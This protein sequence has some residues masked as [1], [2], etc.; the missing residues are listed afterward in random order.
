MIWRVFF[1]S[2]VSTYTLSILNQINTNGYDNITLSGA[3][4]LK[5]GQMFKVE[6]LTQKIHGAIFLGI[7]GG[8][9]GAMF[10][11]VQRIVGKLRKKYI[12]TTSAK[13]LEIMFFSVAT[14]TTSVVII[15][16][17]GKCT[18][19]PTYNKKDLVKN[20]FQ[21]EIRS[22][23]PWQCIHDVEDGEGE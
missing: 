21:E 10:I 8:V 23:K 12:E 6:L 20:N 2:S 17:A 19:M 16:F 9:F 14:I 5:F 18:N 3:G 11:E 4:T 1:C 15:Q 7:L 13:V 22:F